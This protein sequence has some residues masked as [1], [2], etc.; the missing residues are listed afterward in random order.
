MRF[1]F[2]V[3]IDILVIN[4]GII[5]A[6]LIRFGGTLPQPNFEAYQIMWIAITA[7]MIL[8][9]YG[10]GAYSWGKDGIFGDIQVTILKATTAGTLVVVVVTYVNRDVASAFPSSVFFLSWLLNTLLLS[11]WR[12]IFRELYRPVKRVLIVGDGDEGRA[13]AEEIKRTPKSNYHLVGFIGDKRNTGNGINILGGYSDVIQIIEK[14]KIDELIITVP[15]TS[16]QK[17][18]DTI[19]SYENEHVR[20]KTVPDIYEAIIGKLETIQIEPVPL[21]DIDILPITG[22]NRSI[23]RVI[24][25]IVSFSILILSFPILIIIGILIKLDSK[26]P[27]IFTQERVGRDYKLFKIYKFRT[28]KVGAEKDTGPVLATKDDER[29]TRVGKFLRK[30]RLDELPQCINV[31]LGQMSLVGPR[32]ERP[33]FVEQFKQSIPGY[34]KRFK[35]RPGI[36]GLAQVNASYDISP[37]SKLKYDLLYIKNYSLLLD[38][39]VMLKTLLV[40]FSK[41]GAQ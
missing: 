28:M 17:L 11:S 40:M 32:P 7:I 10:S 14:E 5:S 41:R 33:F 2:F 24:D 20:F 12:L 34:S 19:L 22:W 35:V 16:N 9:I 18:W 21:I 26:G 3:I 27:I 6:F 39:K 30:T 4:A 38:I 15:P 37:K 25:I 29:I 8:A 31:F 36:T 13:V 23:K 1:I